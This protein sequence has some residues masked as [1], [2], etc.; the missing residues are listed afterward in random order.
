MKKKFNSDGCSAG[1]NRACKILLKGKRCP[2][3]GACRQ[4]D[5]DYY[6]GGSPRDRLLADVRLK[7]TIQK[8]GYRKVAM[9]VY[10][11]VR[12]AGSCFFNYS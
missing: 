4:H 6:R 7:N 2:W 9:V 5:L 11:S 3:D 8:K 12:L 10:Y 1:L